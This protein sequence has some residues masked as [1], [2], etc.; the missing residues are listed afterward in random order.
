MIIAY[1]FLNFA[2]IYGQMMENPYYNGTMNYTKSLD[3]QLF[4]DFKDITNKEYYKRHLAIENKTPFIVKN[5]RRRGW[6]QE[7]MMEKA[8]SDSFVTMEELKEQEIAIEDE[9]PLIIENS[10]IGWLQKYKIKKSFSDTID[11]LEEL[12][13]QERQ[14]EAFSK[15][16]GFEQDM[17]EK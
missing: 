9:T 14:L 3:P 16:E 2:F 11:T 6:K 13:E 4:K 8:V 1:A 17:K 5:R 15:G 10:R 7:S 12:K